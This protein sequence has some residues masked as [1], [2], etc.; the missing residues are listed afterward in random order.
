M[1]KR[2]LITKKMWMRQMVAALAAVLAIT[3]C[4]MAPG[5]YA[6]EAAGGEQ[7]SANPHDSGPS[8]NDLRKDLS[9]IRDE[10]EAARGEYDSAEKEFKALET[11]ISILNQLIWEAEEQIAE[12]LEQIEVAEARLAELTEQVLALEQEIFDQNSALNKRLRIMYMTDEQ[13]M[14]SVVL[15]SENFVDMMSNLEM[16][17]KIHESDKAFLAELEKKLDDL[18][19]KKAEA[20]SIE[21]SLK[22]KYSEL[23]EYKDQLDEDRAALAAAQWR[24]KEIRD[25]A[26]AEIE[27]L[28]QESKRIEQELLNMTSRWGDYG[29]G[30]M[31]W[32]VWGPVT[33]EFGYRYHPISGR[34]SMHTGIDIGAPS[35]TPVHAA[36]DGI[37]YFAGWNSGGYGNLIMI[38]NGSGIVTMYAHLS[39]FA[40]GTNQIV[41]RGDI[42]GY[43]GSTGNSTGPHLHFEVRVSGTPQNPRGWF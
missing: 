40:S 11:Q 16:V 29:G 43:V 7:P 4:V 36:A 3:V 30:A 39:G 24:V 32:P 34:Y 5:S 31:A 2:A 10:L 23:Q 19:K 41:Y 25:K 22:Q 13:N 38:D 37:V 27:R 33:S 12:L 9:D 1:E 6:E 20:E 21:K 35:G 15:G 28:E 17:R 26:A 8:A 42:I 18:E 14:I